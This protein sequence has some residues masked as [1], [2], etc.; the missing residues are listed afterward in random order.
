VLRVLRN[1]ARIAQFKLKDRRKKADPGAIMRA[2]TVQPGVAN[3]ARLENIEAVSGSGAGVVIQ[4][5][6]VGVCGT[7][8]EI[9]AGKY[10]WAPADRARL[11]LGHEAV[12]RVLST[13][14]NAELK[15][16]DLVVPIVRHPDPVPCPNCAVG[17]WDMCRNGQYTEHGIKEVDGFC[18]E[19]V[20]MEP[21]FLVPVPP[22]L[23]KLA[24]LIEPTSVVAK[25]W[26]H[27]ERIGNRAHWQPRNVLVTGAGPVGLLA[28]LLARQRGLE[29]H[30][31]DRATSGPKPDLAR[32]L[33]AHYFSE[34]LPA[35]LKR[36]PMDIVLECT[37]AASV[38]LE[39][40]GHNAAGAITCLV[41]VS[42]GGARIP[43][44]ISQLNHDMVLEN[45]VVFGTV[46]ANRSH[47]EAAVD[48]LVR[49]DPQWLE[50][51]ITRRVPLE[52]WSEALQSQPNDVKVV[53]EVND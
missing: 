31:L 29:T 18:A 49:A 16:G 40:I 44:D 35:L 51:L 47:Y 13:P 38:I 9:V 7:D 25:A 23:G 4:P 43:V 5:L 8:R 37:G 52:R 3:S 32:A 19:S 27:I 21:Q 53:I 39:V 11:V 15:A 12:A 14:R 24:V 50:S 17:E 30:I 20:R 1:R 48:A 26:D 42:S 22:E 34:G 41:G 45:D 10:G 6:A 2:L 28:A 46:N 33:G 36:T